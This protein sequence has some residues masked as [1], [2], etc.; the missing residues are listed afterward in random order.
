MLHTCHT[1]VLRFPFVADTRDIPDAVASEAIE[2]YRSGRRVGDILAATGISRSHLYWLLKREGDK[3]V[4]ST[5]VGVLLERIERLEAA[6]ARLQ[7][8]S[9]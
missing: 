9:G 7:E 3:P 4:S 6:V 5:D 2:M 8:R 1:T